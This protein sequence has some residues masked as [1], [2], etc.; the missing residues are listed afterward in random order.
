[1]K[2]RN[3]KALYEPKDGDEFINTS[4]LFDFCDLIHSSKK[5]YCLT[6]GTATLAAALK[7]PAIVF[8]GDL[9]PKGYQHSLFHQ[10]F[11]IERSLLNKT[12]DT[13]KVPFRRLKNRLNK[14]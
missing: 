6:S 9:Q 3:E 8:Y 4:T 13:L 1:M 7:K 2:I 10:Y 14:R 5:I 11:L 12:M